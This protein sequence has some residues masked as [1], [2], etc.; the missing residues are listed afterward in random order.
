[1]EQWRQATMLALL[2][3]KAG[4][5]TLQRKK[6]VAT[7][8]KKKEQH[9]RCAQLRIRRKLARTR[10]PHRLQEREEAK[11]DGHATQAATK[12]A[13]MAGAEAK[14]FVPTVTVVCDPVATPPSPP[15][16]ERAGAE[17]VQPESNN[18]EK[19][20]EVKEEEGKAE[21]T[22]MPGQQKATSS[23]VGVPLSL[24]EAEIA[25]TESEKDDETKKKKKK[26][27]KKKSPSKTA[28]GRDAD[29]NSKRPTC[30]QIITRF[31]R[32]RADGE[33]I[34]NDMLAVLDFLQQET[35]RQPELLDTPYLSKRYVEVLGQ[36]PLETE[37]RRSK[38]LQTAPPAGS[39]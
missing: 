34:S 23:M 16:P 4:Q 10:E 15:S 27:K 11:H 24:H 1:M 35:V 17:V 29:P 25:Q 28:E 39:V 13:T 32:A 12:A 30:R 31:E 6:D 26:K 18:E 22:M 33:A 20:K 19:K 21:L 37:L 8:A 2:S 5:G 9:T 7:V 14:E 36:E 3:F 38:R